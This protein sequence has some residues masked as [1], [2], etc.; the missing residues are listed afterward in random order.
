ML[1]NQQIEE[2][3]SHLEKAQNPL[4]FFDNDSDGLCAF[5]ILQRYIGRGKG[6]PIRSFPELSGEYFRKIG[7]LNPDYI[8]ILDKPMVSREFLE[9]VSKHNI[10]IVW[11]DHHEIEREKI[12][13][14]V[15]YYNPLFNEHKQNPP[16]TY[17]CYQISEK[18]QDLWLGVAGCISD[19]FIPEFYEE[20]KNEYPDLATD[21]EDAF[22][23]YYESLIGKIVRI[24]SFALKDRTTNVIDMLRFLV[25]SRSPYD[26]LEEKPENYH[27]HKRF[28]EI[29]HKFKK[30]T[31]KAIEISDDKK[32][33][34]FTYGGDLS[35]SSDISNY[36]SYKFPDKF[37]LVGYI[38]GAKVNISG[39]GKGIKGVILKAIEDFEASGGGH[40]DAVGIQINFNDVEKFKEKI[41]E[42][43]SE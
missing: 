37:V 25:K 14:Y 6:V 26:V 16:T 34:F 12:P 19:K 20:F 43:I 2:I 22:E 36:L 8:F 21:S 29:N 39:R 4:F 9:E 11:I 1:N 7:E 13:E 18:K 35:I 3:K 23:I 41:E 33:L 30:F 28:N 31:Q 42:L 10:P 32:M 40:E 38:S 17:L 15:N 5:L 24:F 27:M